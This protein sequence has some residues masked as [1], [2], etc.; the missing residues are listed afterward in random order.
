MIDEAGEEQAIPMAAA[1]EALSKMGARLAAVEWQHPSLDL[2][3]LYRHH[4]QNESYDERMIRLARLP[5][6]VR[7]EPGLVPFDGHADS[8]AR[9]T[10]R[11][12]VAS[13]ADGEWI[14]RRNGH[15]A[16]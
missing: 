15:D 3:A 6:G 4:R 7:A 2:Y 5:S 13:R 8:Y 9:I 1:K 16:L 14:C 10:S 12:H 11:Y